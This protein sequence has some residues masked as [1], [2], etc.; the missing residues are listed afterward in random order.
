MRPKTEVVKTSLPQRW[1]PRRSV[2]RAASRSSARRRRRTAARRRRGCTSRT[3]RAVFE[4]TLMMV[5]GGGGKL[6]IFTSLHI[7][8][9]SSISLVPP[10]G[11]TLGVMDKQNG[12]ND[13]W[14]AVL[15]VKGSLSYAG[16]QSA[17]GDSLLVHDRI[18]TI[19][20]LQL[21]ELTRPAC[22]PYDTSSPLLTYRR[23]D[24]S[25]PYA[26]CWGTG[27]GETLCLAPV[28]SV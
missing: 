23:I 14:Y 16:S 8:I 17:S 27:G 11:M 21:S 7:S 10:V 5:V 3:G 20:H 12:S 1:R 13:T 19:W 28:P 2:S 22:W 18:I 6:G 9:P 26:L 24:S 15:K 4:Q 25:V